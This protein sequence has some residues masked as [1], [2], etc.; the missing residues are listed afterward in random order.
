MKAQRTTNIVA[1]TFG[2]QQSYA[3][4]GTTGWTTY[5]M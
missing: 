4:K 1:Q 5:C 2:M 3:K